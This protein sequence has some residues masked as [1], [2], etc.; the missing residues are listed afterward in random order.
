MH[1]IGLI[2]IWIITQ[3]KIS[4]CED[5]A[6]ETIQ[7]VKTLT[8]IVNT[9]SKN[10]LTKKRRKKGKRRRKEE[11]KEEGEKKEGISELWDN[12]NSLTCV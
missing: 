10:I 7:T 6:I 2:A 1:W 4:K 11:E 8:Q 5:I 9:D 3:K 12:F